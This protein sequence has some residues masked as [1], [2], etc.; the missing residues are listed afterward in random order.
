MEL[1]KNFGTVEILQPNGSLPEFSYEHLYSLIK[2]RTI[3]LLT[4]KIAYDGI[5]GLCSGL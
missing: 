2:G 4:N 1:L 3:L 5:H